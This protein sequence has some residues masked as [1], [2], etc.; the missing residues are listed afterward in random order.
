MRLIGGND[1]E[2][3][4]AKTWNR[5][6]EW[7][8][9]DLQFAYQEQLDR[10]FSTHSTCFLSRENSSLAFN[11]REAPLEAASHREI[12]TSSIGGAFWKQNNQKNLVS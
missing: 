6:G 12:N 2:F 9:L 4:A 7:K 5:G 3:V 1:P 10:G 8:T 11:T